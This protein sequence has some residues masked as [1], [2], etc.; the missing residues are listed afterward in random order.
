MKPRRVRRNDPEGLRNRLLDEAASLFQM[1]GYHA[2]SIQDVM[3]KTSV[4]GGAL[5]HHFPS[6][7]SL[8]LAVIS[9][10]VAPAVRQT[11]IDPL[12]SAPSLGRG[13]ARVFTVIIDGVEARGAVAGCPLNNLALELTTADPA[14]RDA[15][16]AVF[17]QWQV[18]LIELIGATRGG[19][20]LG[21]EKRSAAASFIVSAY[22]GAMTLA[23][24]AQSALPLRNAAGVLS[25]WLRE[26]DFSA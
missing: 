6:K 12:R 19:S 23:K 9:E 22:S 26:Q 15:I 8:A 5:H 21:R 24:S 13:I 25:H 7:K 11:W 18:A 2:T 20:R 1:R 3:Q 16:D 17:T 14:F 10:R 4:S